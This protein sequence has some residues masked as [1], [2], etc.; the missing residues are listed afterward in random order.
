MKILFSYKLACSFVIQA[1]IHV[2]YIDVQSS[3]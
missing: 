1:R 3:K 2:M